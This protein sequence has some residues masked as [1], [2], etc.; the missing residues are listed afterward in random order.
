MANTARSR[1]RSAISRAFRRP[2]RRATA[3]R[4]MPRFPASRRNYE[5]RG[6]R[7][8]R[9]DATHYDRLPVSFSRRSRQKRQGEEGDPRSVIHA[10]S[11]AIASRNTP[12]FSSFPGGATTHFPISEYLRLLFSRRGHAVTLAMRHLRQVHGELWTLTGRPENMCAHKVRRRR[13]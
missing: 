3:R 13:Y 12:I 8:R 11:A 1:P 2:Y 9:H 4:R 6:R 10:T 5:R 7:H